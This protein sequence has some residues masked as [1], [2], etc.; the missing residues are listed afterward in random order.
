MFSGDRP[1]SFLLLYI[2]PYYASLLW[3]LICTI[4]SL[5][6]QMT[7]LNIT[8]T[9]KVDGLKYYVKEYR[10]FGAQS[11]PV[12]LVPDFQYPRPES[13]TGQDILVLEIWQHLR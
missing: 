7:S 6:L 8:G 3:T 1:T 11:L 5:P 4:W 12:V 10:A 9:M 13:A 2:T